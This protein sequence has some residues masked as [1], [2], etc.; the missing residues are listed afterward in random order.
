MDSTGIGRACVAS[1]GV[2]LV[3]THKPITGKENNNFAL[4]A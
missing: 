4:A 3:K 1:R 2:G